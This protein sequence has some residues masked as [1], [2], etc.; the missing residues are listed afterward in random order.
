M[1]IQ[2]WLVSA[3][4]RTRR[5]NCAH[6][7]ISE[8]SCDQQ[9]CLIIPL[10]ALGVDSVHVGLPYTCLLFL[11]FSHRMIQIYCDHVPLSH[12]T[13]RPCR[14]NTLT[15]RPSIPGQ[16][17]GRTTPISI[18]TDVRD[19]A[20]YSG[21]VLFQTQPQSCMCHRTDLIFVPSGS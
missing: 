4:S 6:K 5:P 7:I 16:E 19:C 1:A 3:I 15:T 17:R 14:P 20:A 12:L 21:D 11:L 18:F 2:D 13:V 9:H 8:N 10:S